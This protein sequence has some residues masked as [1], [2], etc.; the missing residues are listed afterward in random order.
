MITSAFDLPHRLFSEQKMIH[1]FM[2]LLCVLNQ[3]NFKIINNN[4]GQRKLNLKGTILKTFCDR[5]DE[6]KT[7]RSI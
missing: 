4:Q 3:Y 7:N 5:F 6:I 2:D 1:Y